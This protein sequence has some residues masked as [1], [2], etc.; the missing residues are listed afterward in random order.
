MD[1]RETARL[2][3]ER[4]QEGMERAGLHRSALAERAGI[5]RSTLSQLLTPDLARLPRA[6]TVAAI[7]AALQVSLDWLLGLG[8]DDKLDADIL[9][10]SLQVA[11]GP[12]I[13]VD[14]GLDQWHSEAAG[15]KI[16]YV[17]SSLPD[18]LKTDA[19]ID[20]EFRD[21][22]ART[23]DR[24]LSASQSRLAYSRRPET[25]MEV[26]LSVQGVEGFV[27][28]EGIWRGLPA[29]ARSEQVDT[30]IRLAEELYPTL[31]IYLFDGLTH[32]SAPYTVFGP[33]RA[34]VYIG[35]LYFV[36][37]TQEHVRVLTRH[38][39]DLIRAATVQANEVA[40]FLS[41]LRAEI[42]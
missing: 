41:G 34:A 26:C 7:A 5:D 19:V 24:A 30:M 16:R 9:Y 27:R 37:N 39:D 15:Y 17:P 14:E 33:M 1:R 42:A 3:R 12:Q 29:A 8:Q 10:E 23:T 31:R 28:G 40:T 2:F 32:F 18:L 11:A 21:F 13:L 38:F 6:D 35:Q 4:L 20:Y 36:I 25:D 22:A